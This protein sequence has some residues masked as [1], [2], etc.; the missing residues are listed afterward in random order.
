MPRPSTRVLQHAST[1]SPVPLFYLNRV[2][3]TYAAKQS[4]PIS[5]NSM[6]NFGKYGR[7]KGEK[8]EAEKLVRGGNFLRTELP[9]RLSHRLR[10]LQ[11]LPFVVAS[12]PRLQ[13]VYELYLEA[14]EGIR[15]FPPIK[16]LDDNDAF[17]RFMQTTLDKHRVVIPELA[18][19]VSETSPLHL[20]PAAL[21]RIM[22]RMLRSRISRRV[23]TEQ[24]IAL[25]EQFRDR[26]QRK[27]KGR[28]VDDKEETRVGLVDT[29]LNAAD[30]VRRCQEFLKRRKGPEG[31]VPILIE[32]ATDVAF[33]YIEEHLEFMLFE[34]IKNAAFATALAHGSAAPNYPITVTIVHQPRELTIR[35]SDQGGGIPPYGG[36]PP[37]PLDLSLMPRAH[38]GQTT[39]Q[40]V[41]NAPLLSQRLDIFSFSHMRRHYQHHAALSSDRAP[42]DPDAPLPT[43]DPFSSTP[44]AR[45]ASPL[46]YTST[47]LST[48]LADGLHSAPAPP[49]L[50]PR[51]TPA[52]AAAAVSP[53]PPTPPAS[54]TTTTTTTTTHSADALTGI[55]ALRAI[56]AQG[57]TG[58]VSEQLESAAAAASTNASAA[59]GTEKAHKAEEEESLVDAQMRSG[60]GLPLSQMYASYFGGD[61]VV[62]TIQGFGS[63]ARLRIMKFGLAA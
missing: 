46:P 1:K 17:C 6:I 27:G 42:D 38:H 10:D 35:V 43:A 50:D 22:L 62:H 55:M 18:I 33:A 31:Q 16:N 56:G 26:Q 11:E 61:L 12:H 30:V 19:G 32:G 39:Q 54:T 25:T 9:T 29:K 36:L 47:V 53:I 13:H 24:H 4:T 60:I 41:A 51:L 34:L 3:E 57:L 2:I 52:D 15:R 14:F 49:A 58:T 28:D 20:P 5:L 40:M 23:I 59:P 44:L 21:D 63:D 8:E 45:G 37:D 7:N 48:P